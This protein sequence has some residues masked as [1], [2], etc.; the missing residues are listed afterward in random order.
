MSDHLLLEAK[1]KSVELIV[2][3]I[4]SHIYNGLALLYSQSSKISKSETLKMFQLS[5]EKLPYLSEMTLKNDY[6]YLIKNGKCTEDDLKKNIEAIFICY[7]KLDMLNKGKQDKI[8]TSKLN[9]PSNMDFLYE[10]YLASARLIYEKPY[11][12]SHKF[13][14]DVISQNKKVVMEIIASAILSVIDN[15]VSYDDLLIQYVY[16][17]TTKEIN[18]TEGDVDES[19]Y[20]DLSEGTDLNDENLKKLDDLENPSFKTS[21]GDDIL[22]IVSKTGKSFEEQPIASDDESLSLATLNDEV[23]ENG[24]GE[25]EE[26]ELVDLDT[27]VAEVDGA[28]NEEAG[29]EK[30]NDEIEVGE[31]KEGGGEQNAVVNVEEPNAKTEVEAEVE[32]KKEE[33][34]AEIETE[35]EE[36]NQEP[37]EEEEDLS[38]ADLDSLSSD[39]EEEE[40]DEDVESLPDLDNIPENVKEGTGVNDIKSLLIDNY[41]DNESYLKFCKF[42]A[43]NDLASKVNFIQ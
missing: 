22:S 43:E 1:K 13:K 18:N 3:A 23:D 25:G 33:P 19:I 16:N 38:L 12:F 21:I 8:D 4:G 15:L 42:A 40:E 26:E 6:K 9:I 32:V 31:E 28:I 24:E 39:N 7:A 30:P 2:D 10:C 17:G 20:N 29:E 34:N 36:H 27:I 5:L 14:P 37:D 35:V 41:N 11:L